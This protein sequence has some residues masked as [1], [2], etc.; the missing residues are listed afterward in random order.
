M[1]RVVPVLPVYRKFLT[2]NELRQEMIL[3]SWSLHIYL[4]SKEKLC[5]LHVSIMRLSIQFT[6]RKFYSF[7]NHSIL[8][9]IDTM[10]SS[11]ILRFLVES[12][13][14]IKL[15]ERVPQMLFVLSILAG[16]AAWRI[17]A[18]TILPKYMGTQEPRELPYW[19]P[20]K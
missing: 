14:A 1:I 11:I 15:E 7:I 3:L 19:T 4:L 8:Y 13:H 10:H 6:Q 16:V 2:R 18:F 17:W 12:S 9:Y 5:S 20:G